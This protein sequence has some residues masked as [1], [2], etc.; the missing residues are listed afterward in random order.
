MEIHPNYKLCFLT[1]LNSANNFFSQ[2]FKMYTLK[3]KKFSKN[4]L[5]SLVEKVLL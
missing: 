4:I 2:K 1:Y 3:I 5:L